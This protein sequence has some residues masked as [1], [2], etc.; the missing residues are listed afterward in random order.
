[1]FPNKED[2]FYPTERETRLHYC[3]ILNLDRCKTCN[4]MIWRITIDQSN[5]RWH[6]CWSKIFSRGFVKWFFNW[7]R[8]IGNFANPLNLHRFPSNDSNR[9]SE[10]IPSLIQSHGAFWKK[11]FFHDFHFLLLFKGIIHYF[12]IG[13]LWKSNRCIDANVTRPSLLV[14]IV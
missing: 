10:F 9:N 8:P 4:K 2:H 6:C 14:T 12:L 1:M 5:E 13:L 7:N 11:N 3:Q